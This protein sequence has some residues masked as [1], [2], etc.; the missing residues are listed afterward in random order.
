M[1]YFRELFSPRLVETFSLN[2]DLSHDRF[3]FAKLIMATTFTGALR[4]A[5]SNGVDETT[6]LLVASEAGPTTQSNAEALT[7]PPAYNEEDDDTPLPKIQIALL[8]YARLVEP[9]AFFS[10]FP[11]VNKMLWETGSLAEADV[12]FYTGLIVS[13]NP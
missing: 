1:S 9:I 2:K 6:P 10:I 3:R 12:G 5:D 4:G 13:L 7:H 8:C 11:F